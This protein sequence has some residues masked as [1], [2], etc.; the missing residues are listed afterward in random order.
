MSMSFFAILLLSLVLSG[1][2]IFDPES[3]RARNF[4]PPPTYQGSVE[5]GEVNYKNNCARCHGVDMA[6]TAEGPPLMNKTYGSSH[7]ADL[8]FYHAVKNGVKQP[9]WKYGDMPMLTGISPE[10]VS[11]IVAFVRFQQQLRGIK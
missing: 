11:D 10:E 1:C 9:H 7:H 2:D 3:I 5:R 4:L 8:S 6:G